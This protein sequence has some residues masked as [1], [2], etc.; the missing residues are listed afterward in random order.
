[1]ALKSKP[2]IA[3][4]PAAFTD[5]TNEI[6]GIYNDMIEES[7]PDKYALKTL[8]NT[9]SK[10]DAIPIDQVNEAYLNQLNA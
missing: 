7:K 1:M 9:Y 2:I 5:L 4:E 10:L 6:G 8:L 3:A